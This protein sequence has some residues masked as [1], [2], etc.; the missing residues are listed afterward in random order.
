L[1]VTAYEAGLKLK[2]NFKA[3]GLLNR[4]F[5]ESRDYRDYRE[6]G[7]ADAAQNIYGECRQAGKNNGVR[8]AGSG[9]REGVDADA[10]TNIYGDCAQASVKS[11]YESKTPAPESGGGERSEQGAV[12]PLPGTNEAD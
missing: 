7:A 8:D 12:L 9:V 11:P 3:D 6:G 10:S 1:W 5:R 4:G 2:G